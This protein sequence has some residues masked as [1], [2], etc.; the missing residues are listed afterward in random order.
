M[1]SDLSVGEALSAFRKAN[2]IAGEA[3]ATWTCD[4]G[5]IS[6]RLPN[7]RWRRKAIL[8]HDLHHLLTGYPCSLRGEFQMAAWE[9]AA[10]RFPHPA[11]TLFCL[12]L[13]AVGML[14]SPRALWQAFLR[15]RRGRSLYGIEITEGLLASPLSALRSCTAAPAVRSAG[16]T[17]ALAFCL[18]V[19]QA[20]LLVLAPIACVAVLA[21]TG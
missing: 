7:F 5:P 16:I 9:F 14:W 4:V 17:D 11:A 12:P 10:G 19:G 1:D 13:V 2:G 6:L 18:L 3:F 15:G 20:S 8:T 21:L